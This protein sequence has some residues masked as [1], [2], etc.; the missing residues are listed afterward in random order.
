[1]RYINLFILPT[2]QFICTIINDKFL[3]YFIQ[4]LNFKRH[5]NESWAK[6][7]KIA[8]IS[9]EDEEL[10]YLLNQR[11]NYLRQIQS[12]V[13]EP[14]NSYLSPSV[15]DDSESSSDEE[16]DPSKIHIK[17]EPS[18]HDTD[19]KEN[20]IIKD[21]CVT[22]ENVNIKHEII[23]EERMDYEEVNNDNIID[24]EY[25]KHVVNGE[26]INE[27]I[28][29]S[30]NEDMEAESSDID[31]NNHSY[32]HKLE[33]NVQVKAQDLINEEESGSSSSTIKPNIK[34]RRKP[35]KSTSE[36]DQTTQIDSKDQIKIKREPVDYELELDPSEDIVDGIKLRPRKLNESSI[37]FEPFDGPSSE[38]SDFA[39]LSD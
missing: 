14:N 2:Y 9:E 12:I 10:N 23:V 11:S 5:Q 17:T 21:E 20:I 13:F 31:K 27:E 7:K 28:D 37:Y 19:V 33:T 34:H 38:E 1:M 18:E 36:N 4:I 16:S 29:K 8:Q 22:E 25:G 30:E 24:Y 39:D 15:S 32:Q 6:E 26:T 35:K 3:F